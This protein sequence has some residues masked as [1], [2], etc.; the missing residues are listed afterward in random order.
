MRI[1]VGCDEI[2]PMGIE[3]GVKYA[4][5]NIY[6]DHHQFE[7]ITDDFWEWLK[8]HNTWKEQ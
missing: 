8:K 4:V 7:C 1:N 6:G 3:S 5:F 2:H